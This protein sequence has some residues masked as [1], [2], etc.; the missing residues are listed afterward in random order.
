[1]LTTTTGA[2][3]SATGSSIGSISLLP[4]LQAASK[5][6]EKMLDAPCNNFVLMFILGPFK[7]SSR[8]DE[9]LRL[10][11]VSRGAIEK[12]QTKPELII[13]WNSEFN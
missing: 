2:G 10:M 7:L 6:R 5:A 1:M 3:V 11:M 4:L 12:V 8:Q 13:R 9:I